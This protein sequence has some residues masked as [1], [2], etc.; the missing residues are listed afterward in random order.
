L[1]NATEV[2]RER[3]VTEPLHPING[4]IRVPER[5]GLGVELD[6]KAVERLEQVEPR[7]K[8]GFIIISRFDNGATLYTS[9]DPNNPHFM[10]RPDWSRT[11]MPMSFAAP[12][13]SEYWDDDGSDAFDEM[14]TRIRQEGA[15]LAEGDR[16]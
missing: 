9:P 1:V 7:S 10:V 8:P 4:F 14:M 15:V 5:P 12:L 11:L 3:F 6:M 2:S 13:T 16:R